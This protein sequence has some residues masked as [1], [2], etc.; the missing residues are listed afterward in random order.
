MHLKLEATVSIT[1]FRNE[2]HLRLC[3]PLHL[4]S[5]SR[6][7]FRQ[8][9]WHR[10]IVNRIPYMPCAGEQ[11]LE[12][13]CWR[14]ATSR[15]LSSHTEKRLRLPPSPPSLASESL[16]L[17]NSTSTLLTGAMR[18]CRWFFLLRRYV[19]NKTGKR[20]SLESYS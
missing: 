5:V 8:L 9:R 14:V 13:E 1:F 12:S 18:P 6:V 20:R 16:A 3:C 19:P 2:H 15:P 7:P 10:P 11:T 4:A 17:S